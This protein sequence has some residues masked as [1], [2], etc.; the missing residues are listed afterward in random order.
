IDFTYQLETVRTL[1]GTVVDLPCM[2]KNNTI[3]INPMD[4]L[5]WLRDN[6]ADILSLD[7]TITI[8]NN[9][10]SIVSSSYGND[11]Y[12]RTLRI[13]NVEEKDSGLY[14]CVQGDVTIAEVLLEILV[15]VQCV[16]NDK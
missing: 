15:G 3:I 2:D 11:D 4:K 10:L 6:T 1:M 5:I 13:K 8:P 16:Q 9:R 7:R 14:R 12:D